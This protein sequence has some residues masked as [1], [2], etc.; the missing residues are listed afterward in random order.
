M[1]RNIILKTIIFALLWI[2]GSFFFSNFGGGAGTSTSFLFIGESIIGSNLSDD[3]AGITSMIVSF[4]VTA[5]VYYVIA[6]I[7]TLILIKIF[8]RK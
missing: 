2:L 6:E 1:A 8:G 3:A 4:I 7:I 5:V